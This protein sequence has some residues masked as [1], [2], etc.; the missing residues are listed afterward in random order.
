MN[1]AY[2]SILVSPY[3]QRKIRRIKYGVKYG[4]ITAYAKYYL[5]HC[6]KARATLPDPTY[7]KLPWSWSSRPF[8]VQIL[9]DYV[10]YPI[11]Y[12]ELFWG[13]EV[14]NTLVENTN[15]YIQYRE[16][17]HKENKAEKKS[18]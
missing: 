8:D 4:R 15:V 16:A 18:R 7:E 1:T 17:R 14:W 5:L 12:F 10:Q 6:I 11:Y 3:V 13:L 9:P 2:A